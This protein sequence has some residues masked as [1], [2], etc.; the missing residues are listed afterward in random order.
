MDFS[1]EMA[2][3]AGSVFLPEFLH[4]GGPAADLQGET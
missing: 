3:N 2:E 1:H 4:V